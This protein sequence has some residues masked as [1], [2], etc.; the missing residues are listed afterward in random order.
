MKLCADYDVAIIGAGPAGLTAAIY[1]RRAGVKCV[2]FESVA[3]GGTLNKTTRIENYPGYT[4]DDGTTLAFRMYGQVESL[5]A[6]LKTSKVI[7]LEKDDACFKIVTDK[8]TYKASYVII[9]S[10]RIPRKLDVDGADKFEGRGIS[11]C[12]ICDG[13]LYK[14]K[15]VVVIGGGNSALEAATYMSNIANKVYIINRSNKLKAAQKEQDDVREATNTE[16]IYNAKVTSIVIEDD[17]IVG[18][19]IDD[20]TKLEVSGIFVCIGLDANNAYYQNLKL[21]S[22]GQGLIVDNNMKTSDDKVYACGDAISKSLYQVVTATS[23]GAIAASDIIN[24]IKSS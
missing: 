4:E 24:R 13:A 7:N 16:V 15:N 14:N 20:D 22:D 2:I 3:P 17:E 18:V 12:A 9:A 1:L 19:V 5:G 21:N 11:Y 6:D 10:G 8:E 23:E